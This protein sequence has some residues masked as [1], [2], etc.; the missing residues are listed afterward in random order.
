[1]NA[2]AVNGATFHTEVAGQGPGLVFIHAGVADCR[3]WDAEFAAFQSR[4]RAVRFDMRGFGRTP[5]PACK[6][7]YHDDAASV[8]R[9]SGVEKATLVGC[10]FGANVAVETCL[11]FPDLVERLVL[12]AP[13]LGEGGDVQE[14]QR[15]DEAEEAALERGDLEGATELNLRLWVDGPFRLPGEVAPDV[16]ERVRVMQLENF[17]IPMPDGIERVRLEPS[18]GERLGEIAVPTLVVVG[19]LDVPFLGGVAER[20]E[21]EV[22]GARRVVIE[23][24]AHMLNLEK[25]REFQRVLAEF[26][27]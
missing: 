25:P 26:L 22:P 1:M 12:I 23:G 13:G 9:A 24:A 5:M 11:A 2:T 21:R 16:R 20:I 7:S 18:A 3:M 14:I 27:A 19:A 6:F 15:F 10:S 17:R 4:F 8:M